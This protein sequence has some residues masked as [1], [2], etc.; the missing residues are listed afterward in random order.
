VEYFESSMLDLVMQTST[1]LPADV[2]VAISEALAKD[3]AG[4]QSASA[5]DV[6]ATNIDMATGCEGAICQ[7]T[8]MPT[9]EILHADVEKA[10]GGVLAKLAA[11]L[12]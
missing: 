8:G 3:T 9:F 1:N 11:P 4:S 5:L 10:S 12:F 2:R 6:I 7:D